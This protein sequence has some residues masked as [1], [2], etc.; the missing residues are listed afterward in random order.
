MNFESIQ[1]R[2][3]FFDLIIDSYHKQ[4]FET[5]ER[6]IR[7][8]KQKE[9]RELLYYLYNLDRNTHLFSFVLDAIY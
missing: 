9:E 8:L 4:D 2:N 5:V 7:A 1:Q 6:M 3:D